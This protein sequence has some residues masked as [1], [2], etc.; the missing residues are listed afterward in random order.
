MAARK[1]K[2][3]ANM[4]AS[5]AANDAAS[6]APNTSSASGKKSAQRGRPRR[7][8][9]KSGKKAAR[10]RVARRSAA[11][12]RAPVRGGAAGKKG[13]RRRFTEAQRQQILETARR[14]GLTGRQVQDRFGITQVTYYLWRRKVGATRPRL[15]QA[16]A[17][18]AT[19]GKTLAGAM[20]IA[21]MIRMEIRKR[22]GQLV[23]EILSSE[24]EGATGAAVRGRR[25][26]RG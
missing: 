25:R 20:N 5:T 7:S 4:D 15:Q 23:P 21:D 10:G 9:K 26:R 16:E 1:S 8:A 6:G 17:A 11:A 2:S 19:V 3:S 18:A 14:E 24:I 22:I 12:R 13:T